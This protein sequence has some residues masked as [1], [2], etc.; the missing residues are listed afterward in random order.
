MTDFWLGFAVGLLV[1]PT[2]AALVIFGTVIYAMHAIKH[3][4][5]MTDQWRRDNT[6]ES[7]KR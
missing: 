5:H 1:E 4:Q 7:G 2:V 6:Y 3:P